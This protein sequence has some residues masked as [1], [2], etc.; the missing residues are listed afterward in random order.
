MRLLDTGI[1]IESIR[2][3]RLVPGAISVI[4]LLEILRGVED[5][6]RRN[7]KVL[8]EEAYHIEPLDNA[9]ILEYSSLY[10]A[11]KETG[12]PIPDTDL[13]IAATAKTRNYELITRDQH[14]DRLKDYGLRII[15]QT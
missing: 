5:D 12:Q 2:E 13:M 1:V 11:L 6:K 3:N 15:T 10:Q 14:F 8:M 4:T 7:M 9:V